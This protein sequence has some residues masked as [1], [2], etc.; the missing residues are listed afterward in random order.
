MFNK[1]TRGDMAHS[2]MS[3][4]FLLYPYQ[5]GPANCVH[6]C[7]DTLPYV[8]DIT[9]HRCKE[10]PAFFNVTSQETNYTI[11]FGDLGARSILYWLSTDAYPICRHGKVLFN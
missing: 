1:C 3:V 5:R 10:H 4:Y 9:G 8:Y 7:Y 11:C 6:R 2:Y